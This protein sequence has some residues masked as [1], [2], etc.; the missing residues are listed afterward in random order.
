LARFNQRTLPLNQTLHDVSIYF[1]NEGSGI[2]GKIYSKLSGNS[3][4][5][6]FQ[7]KQSLSTDKKINSKMLVKSK[8]GDRRQP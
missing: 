8:E 6:F 5:P 1:F 3:R 2:Q 4:K 7:P